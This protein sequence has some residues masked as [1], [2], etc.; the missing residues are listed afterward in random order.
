MMFF[1]SVIR[2]IDFEKTP[3]VLVRS[4][5][6]DG[7]IRAMMLV[8]VTSGHV[9][10]TPFTVETAGTVFI[11]DAFRLVVSADDNKPHLFFDSD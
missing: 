7:D 9:K 10:V 1:M 11:D 3:R 8:D 6:Y 2:E 5:E 4:L